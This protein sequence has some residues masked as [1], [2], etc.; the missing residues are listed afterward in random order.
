MARRRERPLSIS[1]FGAGK[2][3]T[4]LARAARDA[5]TKGT[6]RAARRGLPR[7]VSAD[8]VVVA[9]RDRDV[10]GVAERM[11]DAGVVPRS[12]VEV[13]LSTVLGGASR[14]VARCEF[15]SANSFAEGEGGGGSARSAE[16]VRSMRSTP[17]NSHSRRRRRS[18]RG[19]GASAP[20]RGILRII[21]TAVH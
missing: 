2:V 8:V 16:G 15:A 10:G 7:T 12:A 20:P 4:A 3:G 13:R 19:A 14:S 1:V 21:L 5:G 9:V 17:R 6:L 11:R 18:R